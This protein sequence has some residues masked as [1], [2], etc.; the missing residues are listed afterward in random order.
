[1]ESQDYQQVDDLHLVRPGR[2]GH[3]ALSWHHR[4]SSVIDQQ[5]T[6][7]EELQADFHQILGPSLMVAF[8]FLGNTLFLTILVSM[9]ST[10]FSHIATNAPAEI[11]FRRAVLTLEG[12]KG[13]AIFAY[14]PPFNVLAIIVLAPLKLCVS[15]RWFH[16]IHVAS[17]RLINLPV[18]LIIALAERRTLWAGTDRGSGSSFAAPSGGGGG[19]GGLPLLSPAPTLAKT[20]TI[21]LR[22]RFWDRW[23]ITHSDI[24]TVFEVPV[25]ESVLAEIAADDDVTRHLIRRQ[26]AGTTR[27]PTAAAAAATPVE[28]PLSQQQEHQHQQQQQ[29]QQQQKQHRQQSPKGSHRLV[30]RRDSIAPFPGLR[31]ELQGVLT[32]TAAAAGDEE[33]VAVGDV[34]E[35]LDGLEERMRRIEALLERLV[36]GGGGGGGG[37]ESS[38]G[39]S[40]E[41]PRGRRATLVE[42]N[43]EA[44]EE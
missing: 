15:P 44:E 40:D 32:T 41:M 34:A 17:V 18:L 43:R 24:S 22:R 11:Q 1:M 42:L 12:V 31:P 25:P 21:R 20:P 2:V 9:L 35:R 37:R 27:P 30:G 7:T 8:A 39:R 13:D 3:P 19:G 6:L 26:F 10:T 5:P 28:P 23:R 16:K 38:E 4:P 33:A 36:D 29:Q 14:P